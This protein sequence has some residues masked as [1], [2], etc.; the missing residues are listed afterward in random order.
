MRHSQHFKSKINWASF[1][2]VRKLVLDI[3]KET[4]HLLLLSV[5]PGGRVSKSNLRTRLWSVALPHV[6][7]CS[8]R[9]VDIATL[10]TCPVIIT[11]SIWEIYRKEG[12]KYRCHEINSEYTN[13]IYIYILQ[14]SHLSFENYHQDK[15]LASVPAIRIKI[16]QVL[17]DWAE[18]H[19]A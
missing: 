19:Y 1:K 13:R 6:T 4:N 18:N 10:G 3:R 16:T 8:K 14:N 17:R 11:C 12:N 9:K 5:N 2:I 15:I 7:N